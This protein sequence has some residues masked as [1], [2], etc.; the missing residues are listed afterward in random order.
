MKAAFRCVVAV[1]AI[2]GISGA[3][4][5]TWYTDSR[6][7]AWSCID[8][9]DGTITITGMNPQMSG[10]VLVP[11]LLNGKSVVRINDNAFGNNTLLTGITVPGSIRH[12]GSG[13]IQL[14][15]SSQ[16][17]RLVFMNDIG[18]LEVQRNVVVGETK[19]LV[20]EVIPKNGNLFAGWF[21]NDGNEIVNPFVSSIPII[22]TPRWKGNNDSDRFGRRSDVGQRQSYKN[23]SN[24]AAYEKSK[25]SVAV[26]NGEDGDGTG[27]LCEMDGKKYFVTNKHVADQRGRIVAKFV[28]G[29][30]MT[31]SL[32]SSID[33]AENRDLVRFVVS[34]DLPCLYP[35]SDTPRIGERIEFY[36]NAGGG[37]VITMTA[38]KIL[39]V[40]MER[41]EID[42]PI[43]GG[44]SGS[45]LV[46]ASDG[47]VI[48]V[49]TL[50]KFNRLNNDLS[51][52][53]TRYDP[54]VK[55]TREFA[56][57]FSGVSWRNMS[58]K[59]FLSAVNTYKDYCKF[60]TWMKNICVETSLVYEYE[61]PDLQFRAQTRLNALMKKIA[62]CDEA[63]K[64]N[65]DR[66]SVLREKYPEPG[67]GET[68][69]VNAKKRIR[70][71]LWSSY[72]VRRE[73]LTTVIAYAKGDNVLAKEEQSDVIE[74]FDWMFRKYS[75][76]F[77][78]QLQG[79]DLGAPDPSPRQAPSRYRRFRWN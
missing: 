21:D 39:A 53:G 14:R 41:I 24:S 43:Q 5:D 35:S 49:T 27:F 54:K 78:R 31:F 46:L 19:H 12:I 37:E 50:S 9:P 57:R 38:G 65:V 22:V 10:T 52:V 4:A 25:V 60:F 66:L 68:E 3:F 77:R 75:E 7:I 30:K 61:L 36:G 1:M 42:C 69:I 79:Y 51:K 23:D 29:T 15:N 56:V 33:V 13:V 64:K 18:T 32:D 71:S 34:T 16:P 55:L 58:Y 70:D 72:K 76:K 67:R 44:N 48:G 63:L 17:F 2:T 62:R 40:G 11:S 59:S 20:T 28:D 74:A 45:P 73:V 8:N 47:K 6:D 26:V